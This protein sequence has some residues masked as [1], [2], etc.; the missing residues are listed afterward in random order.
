MKLNKEEYP[1]NHSSEYLCP[2]TLLTL[3]MYLD[4]ISEVIE[5]YENILLEKKE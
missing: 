2:D 4:M 3:D 5:L 1:L